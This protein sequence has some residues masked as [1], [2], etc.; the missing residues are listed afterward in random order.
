MFLLK[1]VIN[2][3][4]IG[5]KIYIIII[6]GLI[7]IKFNV[8]IIYIFDVFSKKYFEK[9]NIFGFYECLKKLIFFVK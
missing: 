6:I 5:L 2:Y 1:V 9:K 8:I 4:Y 3:L 7:F